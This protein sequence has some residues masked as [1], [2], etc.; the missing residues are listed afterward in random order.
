MIARESIETAYC[1]FHQKERV[2]AH[3]TLDWQKDDIEQAISAYVDG[4]DSA[5]YA[6][7]AHGRADFLRNHA[8]FHADLMAAVD[9]M[10]RM[11]FG[12]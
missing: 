4:M 2:F 7:L 12:K 9:E 10:E 3:S 6:Q 5:L 1:F 11:L 8:T